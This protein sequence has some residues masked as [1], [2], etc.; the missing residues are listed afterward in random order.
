MPPQS[1]RILARVSSAECAA[2]LAHVLLSA[3]VFPRVSLT[4]C[5]GVAVSVA[6]ASALAMSHALMRSSASASSSSSLA[7]SSSVSL[8]PIAQRPSNTL[9]VPSTLFLSLFIATVRAAS[10]SADWLPFSARFIVQ[11][12]GKY[13]P[14][15]LNDEF[16][17]FCAAVAVVSVVYSSVLQFMPIAAPPKVTFAS[18]HKKWT[19][20]MLSFAHSIIA[21][22]VAISTS[23]CVCFHVVYTLFAQPSL[24]SLTNTIVSPFTSVSPS[25]I[26]WT[27]RV[28]FWDLSAVLENFFLVS[29]VVMFWQIYAVSH[30][31]TDSLPQIETRVQNLLPVL[32]TVAYMHPMPYSSTLALQSL[33]T[34][35]NMPPRARDPL[36]NA[37]PKAHIDSSDSGDSVT[38]SP[39][40]TSAGACLRIVEGFKDELDRL[41]AQRVEVLGDR[42]G[43]KKPVR[44][45]VAATNGGL[46]SRG[47]VGNGEPDA[48]AYP[49]LEKSSVSVAMRAV[50]AAGMGAMNTPK[51]RVS[52][53]KKMRLLAGAVKP[54][55]GKTSFLDA[56]QDAQMHDE[57]G[58][59]DAVNAGSQAVRNV[60][61]R[62][63][64]STAEDAKVFGAGAGGLYKRRNGASDSAGDAAAIGSAKTGKD[65]AASS[66]NSVGIFDFMY[67]LIVSLADE[68]KKGRGKQLK[69]EGITKITKRTFAEYETLSIAVEAVSKLLIAATKEDQYGIIHRDIPDV[70]G[71]L[72]S[73][74]IA[75][76]TFMAQ[77]PGVADFSEKQS[78]MLLEG[79][80]GGQIV[81]KD[82]YAV[83][84]LLQ[85]NIYYITTHLG[86]HLA[87]Y[88]F[89]P[90]VADKLK[91]FIEFLE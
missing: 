11:S 79:F 16:V 72:L 89:D 33:R 76:E 8:S 58:A 20:M 85:T 36:F 59:K 55:P 27:Y 15:H 62:V 39:W 63:N 81:L 54:S 61:D 42:G 53:V 75:V 32:S 24:Y 90:A 12:E 71:S 78:C 34:L 88:K 18:L 64:L 10:M 1:Q 21:N 4:A 23:F 68:G 22:T 2:S 49:K 35:C 29:F 3:F 7:S 5:A 25:D 48:S 70:L 80:P 73:C 9:S 86:D 74:L 77:P 14:R 13:G 31:C 84:V 67:S 44:A 6:V 17:Y 46:A 51:Y 82:A 87:R 56:L 60:K 83:V 43:K 37:S 28:S 91:R 57:L 69:L 66:K 38:S 47:S 26:P 40:I 52:P 45:S 19:P 30:V 50:Q 65:S 41:H